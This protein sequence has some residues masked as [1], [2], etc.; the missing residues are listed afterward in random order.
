MSKC[1]RGLYMQVSSNNKL[2]LICKLE[3]MRK[4]NSVPTVWTYKR[5]PNKTPLHSVL[6]SPIIIMKTVSSFLK[7]RMRYHRRH[8]IIRLHTSERYSSH[9]PLIHNHWFI[10]GVLLY[11]RLCNCSF[12]LKAKTNKP[13]FLWSV[14]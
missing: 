4:H 14:V 8:Y 1:A 13:Q 11:Y 9:V 5:E 12:V 2:S 7:H 3:K 10:G 6:A